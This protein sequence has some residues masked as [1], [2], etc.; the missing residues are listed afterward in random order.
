MIVVDASVAAKW[1]LPEIGS[2]A[3]V[4][5]QEGPDQLIAPDLIRMEVAGSITRRMRVDKKEERL[6]ADVALSRCAKWFRLLDEATV[7]LIPEAELL[8]EAVKLSVEIKHTLQDCM[9]LA[10]ARGLNARLVTA[11]RP[12]HGRAVRFYKHIELLPGCETN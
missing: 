9:Y 3:A 4:E 11:D 7:S 5:L 2:A 12:F 6:A 8:Q 10:A 1:F